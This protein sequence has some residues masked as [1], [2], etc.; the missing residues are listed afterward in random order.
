VTPVVHDSGQ[1][2]L[3][4]LDLD[5]HTNSAQENSTATS[6]VNQ[7]TG[8]SLPAQLLDRTC[9]QLTR[10]S[11]LKLRISSKQLTTPRRPSSSTPAITSQHHEQH[12]CYFPC[13]QAWMIHMDTYIGLLGGGQRRGGQGD[14][15]VH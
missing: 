15:E 6:M 8:K 7:E 10:E 5:Q 1:V 2:L 9:H 13:C 11:A 4:H 12:R 14:Q 3:D